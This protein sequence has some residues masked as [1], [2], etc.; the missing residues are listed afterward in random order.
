VIPILLPVFNRQPLLQ[1]SLLIFIFAGKLI[2][3]LSVSYKR[4]IYFW[5]LIGTTVMQIIASLFM[6]L[7]VNVGMELG[8]GVKWAVLAG[9]AGYNLLTIL[10]A[11]VNYKLYGKVARYLYIHITN[12]LC[13]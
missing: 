11:V 8:V 13:S 10:Q 4:K 2:L 1:S 9:L 7:T 6:V 5:T 12:E 3:Q